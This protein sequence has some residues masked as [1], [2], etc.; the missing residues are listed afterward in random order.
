MT[1]ILLSP[2]YVKMRNVVLRKIILS[3]DCLLQ[4][5]WH[6]QS[7]EPTHVLP[8]RKKVYSIYIIYGKIILN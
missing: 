2:S 3:S 6:E 5:C 7:F 4:C 8:T 1:I